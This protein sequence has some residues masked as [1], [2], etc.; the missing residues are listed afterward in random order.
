LKR[1]CPRTAPACRGRSGSFPGERHPWPHRRVAVSGRLV[2]RRSWQERSTPALTPRLSLGT[3]KPARPDA[4]R[5]LGLVDLLPPHCRHSVGGEEPTYRCLGPRLGR[6]TPCVP[7]NERTIV[8]SM[9]IQIVTAATTTRVTFR[10]PPSVR[11]RSKA[12]VARRAERASALGKRSPASEWP[13]L[14]HSG[15]RSTTPSRS[16]QPTACSWVPCT[17]NWRNAAVARSE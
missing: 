5:T 14:G 4:P 16:V 15:H 12:D 3:A 8:R 10:S 17:W 6:V 13:H 1:S 11:N 9:I 2:L 7:E